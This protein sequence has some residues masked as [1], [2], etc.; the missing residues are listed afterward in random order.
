MLIYLIFLPDWRQWRRCRTLNM[1]CKQNWKMSVQI[2]SHLKGKK[3]MSKV[4]WIILFFRLKSIKIVWIWLSWG[5]SKA[6]MP[7]CVLPWRSRQP[8][9]LA[10]FHV[11]HPRLHQE[12]L[13]FI[14]MKKL[15]MY[16]FPEPDK[17]VQVIVLWN[18][19]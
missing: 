17:F 3:R 15:G 19:Y 11:C 1:N 16:N 14:V 12:M 5:T 7:P 4:I 13:F 9:R 8:A 2:E 6:S 18:H 10:D